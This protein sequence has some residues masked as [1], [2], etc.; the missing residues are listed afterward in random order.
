[1]P[2]D[3]TRKNIQAVNI[4]LRLAQQERG[5]TMLVH[6]IEVIEMSSHRVDPRNP[7]QDWGAISH[8]I[9]ILS[10]CPVLLVK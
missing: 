8:K 5:E 1:M 9:S 10:Q 3:L 2:V 4:A 7:V 6:V